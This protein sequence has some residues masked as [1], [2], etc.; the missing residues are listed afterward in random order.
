[1][2]KNDAATMAAMRLF[3]AFLE[4][5]LSEGTGNNGVAWKAT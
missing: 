4:H 2:A 1:M 3:R 5:H